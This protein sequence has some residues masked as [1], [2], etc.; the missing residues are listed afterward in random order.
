MNE[1]RYSILW[2]ERSEMIDLVHGTI[3]ITNLPADCRIEAMCHDLC[4]DAI[5]LRIWSNE[6]AIT[7]PGQEIKSFAAEFSRV[8]DGR[9]DAFRRYVN[10]PVFH[11]LVSTLNDFVRSTGV[12][13]IADLEQTLIIMKARSQDASGDFLEPQIVKKG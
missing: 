9:K 13:G 1:R 4:R 11:A 5:G 3:R 2:I 6:F 8:Q 10:D 7:A 12:L